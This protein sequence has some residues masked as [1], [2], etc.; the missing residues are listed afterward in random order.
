MK[1]KIYVEY[2]EEEIRFA[3]TT[4]DWKQLVRLHNSYE[5]LFI[6]PVASRNLHYYL[7]AWWIK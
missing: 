1:I 6:R 2:F 4:K 3:Y 7:K 5:M